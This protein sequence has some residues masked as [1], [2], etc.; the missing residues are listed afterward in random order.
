MRPD[1]DRI[2]D[3]YQDWGSTRNYWS[4]LSIYTPHS[5]SI[6]RYLGLPSNPIPAIEYNIHPPTS[7]LLLLPLGRLQYP[8]AVLVWNLIS[9]LAFLASLVIVAVVLPALR[10]LIVPGLVLLPFCHP[11]YENLYQGQLNLLL[12]LLVTAIWALER[13]DHGCSAGLLLGAAAAI[14]LFPIYL[15]IYYAAQG[16][17][18]PLIMALVSFLSLT[19]ITILIL[20]LESYHAYLRI[21]LPWN[22]EFRI[23]GYNFSIAGFWHKLFYPVPGESIIPLW[24]SLALARSGSLFSNLIVTAIVA[25][26]AYHAVTSTQRDLAF[27]AT[28]TA[29]L[30]VSPVTWDTSLPILLVPFA[31]LVHRT[32]TARSHWP[33]VALTLILMI[34]W[35]P[36]PILTELALAGRSRVDY[37]WT[38]MLGAPSLK[39]YALLGTFGL[40]LAACWAET[41]N[42]RLEP[43]NKEIAR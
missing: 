30:L 1:H 21:V 37:S 12:V 14:K 15:A 28:V 31:L 11:M 42:P 16:R 26:V 27:A 2:I 36:Q 22:A 25:T 17:G 5:T 10:F 6:P 38:F 20:G 19:L 13:S 35:A 4:G 8:D 32:V 40:G 24:S 18:R 43:L 3:F 7:V 39:F 23:L 33:M 9:L 29:M 34:N 41:K